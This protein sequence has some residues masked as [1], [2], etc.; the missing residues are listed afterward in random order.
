MYTL[1]ESAEHTCQCGII[2]TEHSREH[3]CQLGTR[4]TAHPRGTAVSMWYYSYIPFVHFTL[5]TRH[6]YGVEIVIHIQRWKKIK[7][8]YYGVT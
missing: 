6:D 2:A 5:L 3:P 4:A 7:S 1:T 8:T